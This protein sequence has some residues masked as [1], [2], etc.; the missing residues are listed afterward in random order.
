MKTNRSALVAFLLVVCTGISAG[1]EQGVTKEKTDAANWTRHLAEAGDSS[2]MVKLGHMLADC[3]GVTKDE[4]EAVK[5][6]RKAATG[7]P[8]TVTMTAE[9][10]VDQEQVVAEIE[11]CGG[12]VSG[13]ARTGAVREVKFDSQRV[14]AT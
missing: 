3:Q 12:K 14:E 2:G 1:G 6:Y 5:W 9:E 10:L 7:K 4:T 13:R 8:A 11:K